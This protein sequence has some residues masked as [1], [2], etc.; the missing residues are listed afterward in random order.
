MEAQELQ[1]GEPRAWL[2]FFLSSS[3]ISFSTVC[4]RHWI[5]NVGMVSA[6]DIT[7]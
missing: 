5:S 2:L 3:P 7:V 4:L 6:A 1:K